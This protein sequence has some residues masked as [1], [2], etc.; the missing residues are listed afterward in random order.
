LTIARKIGKRA[1]HA[2][3]ELDRQ[4]HFGLSRLAPPRLDTL[5]RTPPRAEIGMGSTPLSP[6]TR[7]PPTTCH[8]QRS[9]DKWESDSCSAFQ[10]VARHSRFGDDGVAHGHFDAMGMMQQLGVIPSGPPA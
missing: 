9:L 2:L 10:A 7:S 4:L 3:R 1:Y 6:P 5:R 8:R